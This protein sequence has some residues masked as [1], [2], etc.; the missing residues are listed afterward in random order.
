MWL[1]PSSVTERPTARSELP[2][3]RSAWAWVRGYDR[4]RARRLVRR[5]D[6]PPARG[7]HAECPEEPRRRLPYADAFRIGR[8]DQRHARE[9]QPAESLER[10]RFRGDGLNLHHREGAEP[11]GSVALVHP[12]QPLGI[13]KRQR[14]EQHPVGDN[15]DGR[16]RADG[17][18]ED[19]DH[20]QGEPG[21]AAESA[22]GE[23]DVGGEVFQRP[24]AAGV[25]DRFLHPLDAAEGDPGLALGFGAPG[26]PPRLRFVLQVKAQLF[27]ELALHLPAKHEGAEPL[28]QVTQDRHQASPETGRTSSTAL[29]AAE[30]RCHADRS[31]LSRRRPAGVRT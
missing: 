25:A 11:A 14:S 19:K 22:E 10:A 24:H 17:D 27:L 31:A 13:G 28:A 1:T 4:R 9:A 29:I 7:R 16:G 6:E 21:I 18:A 2:K 20:G 23:A 15:E 5:L 8:A 3:A 12:H 30:T 26:A